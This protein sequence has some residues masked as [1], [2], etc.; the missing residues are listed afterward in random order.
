M[1]KLDEL[2]AIVRKLR[3]PKGCPWDR[4][5]NSRSLLP[6]FLE[7]AYEAADAI[8]QGNPEQLKKELGDVLLH[9]VFQALIAEEEGK[10]DFD[11]ILTGIIDKMKSRHPHV[12]QKDR[13]YKQE[14]IHK[15]WEK[16]K[17]AREHVLDGIPP[18]LSELHR[19]YRMQEK[20]AA[21]G[22]DWD[23]ID[24]V[25]KKLEEEIQEFRVAKDSGSAE[26][27]EEEM[28]D[29]LFALVNLSR[30]YGLHPDLAL[31]HSN[32]KF[33]RR[34]SAVEDYFKEKGVPMQ[35]A[36][37]QELDR[38]WNTIKKQES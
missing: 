27:M 13:K 20:A 22:F 38:I 8:R 36:G 26:A 16:Q 9:L 34:F 4:D 28:G 30:F 29:V 35:D 7:E 33:Y 1:K 6:Y 14:E 18:E 10:F 24:D 12:F 37:L 19:A 21:Q 3:S 2:I 15:T 17:E 11:A 32:Q 31:M 5:Q 23:N 25:W